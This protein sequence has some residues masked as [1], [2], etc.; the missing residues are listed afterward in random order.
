MSDALIGYLM[1][2]G[3]LTSFTVSIMATRL[4][5]PHM[6]MALGFVVSTAVNVVVASV[7]VLLDQWWRAHPLRASPSGPMPA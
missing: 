1:A 2:L 7:L 4:A 6:S 3:S 5:L